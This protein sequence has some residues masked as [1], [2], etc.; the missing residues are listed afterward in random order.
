[1]PGFMATVVGENF[2]FMVDDEPQYLEFVRTVYVDADD[3]STAEQVALAQVREELLA[4]AML[5]EAAE[6]L[7]SIEEICQ[8]DVLADK[9]L[10]GD[11]IWFFPDDLLD[12]DDVLDDEE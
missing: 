10:E 6:Q 9:D 1:M 12:D 3:E 4:Q 11:F 8:T 7:I 5:D 2:K